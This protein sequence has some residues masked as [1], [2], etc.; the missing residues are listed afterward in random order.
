[1]TYTIRFNK[2][3][4]H[5]NITGNY[6]IDQYKGVQYINGYLHVDT[7]ESLNEVSKMI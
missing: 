7:K 3:T 2:M 6:T 1:M 5:P 4:L